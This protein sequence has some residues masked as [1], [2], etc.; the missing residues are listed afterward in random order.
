MR[1]LNHEGNMNALILVD[2][3]N[4]FCAGGAL[5]VPEGEAVIPQVNRL[6]PYFPLVVATQDWHPPHHASFAANHAGRNVGDV[7]ELDGKA[8]ILWPVHCVQD[9]SG[10][11]LH[12]DLEQALLTKIIFKGTNPALDSYSG[13]FDNGHRHATGLGDYLKAQHMTRVYVCGLATDYCVKFTV[14]DALKLG[15]ETVLIE[16][17]C[18]GVNLQPNDSR[19]AIAEIQARG[20]V[21]MNA[22]E[23]ATELAATKE[24]RC[25]KFYKV[26]EPYGEFSNFAPFPI[27]LDGK[28]WPT[29]EHYFQAQKFPGT[30]YEIKIRMTPSPSTAAKLGRSR[31]YPLRADWEE[32]K[33]GIMYRAVLA[34]VLQHERM[35]RKLLATGSAT[36]IEHTKNDCYWADGGDGTGRNMLGQI[37]MQIRQ[38]LQHQTA[39]NTTAAS[40]P[41]K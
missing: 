26:G 11:E 1:A 39:T 9:S 7:V 38:E 35:Q 33:D 21:V 24:P 16:D 4:D 3:Q 30:A 37:L 25:I 2:L 28:V 41:K 5:A 18:R 32:V 40:L 6:L 14:L 22:A 8:Q 31:S 17:C 10:A 12:P 29:S 19:D 13:F 20:A 27:E 15:F 34:K 36:L 23:V